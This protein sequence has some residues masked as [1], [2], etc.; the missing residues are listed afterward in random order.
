MP[1]DIVYMFLK[2]VKFAV[3]VIMQRVIT[4]TGA[5]RTLA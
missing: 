2:R 4:G 1:P 5:S 3:D